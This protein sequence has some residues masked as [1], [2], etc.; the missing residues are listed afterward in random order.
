MGGD[1]ST[2]NDMQGLQSWLVKR[3][4]KI[5]RINVAHDDFDGEN[6]NIQWAIEQ[7]HSGG[8]NAGGRA[9]KHQCFGA[10]LDES[11]NEKRG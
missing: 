6:Y 5:K 3:Q 11:K 9:P 10:W 7:Y 8:F 1:C 2:I 4:A